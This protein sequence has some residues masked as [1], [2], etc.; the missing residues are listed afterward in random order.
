MR[1]KSCA[2][3]AKY[4]KAIAAGPSVSTCTR[5]LDFHEEVGSDIDYMPRTYGDSCNEKL[6]EDMEPIDPKSSSKENPSPLRSDNAGSQNN[7]NSDLFVKKICVRC[8]CGGDMMVCA[9]TGCPVAF[10]EKCLPS[11]PKFDGSGNYYCPYCAYRG[12]VEKA[13]MLRRK[14]MLAKRNLLKFLNSVG[15]GPKRSE[16]EAIVHE[17]QTAFAPLENQ[18]QGNTKVGDSYNK[19]L[20]GS[21]VDGI[22]AGSSPLGNQNLHDVK[23]GHGLKEIQKDGNIYDK[24]GCSPRRIQN[25]DN[26]GVAVGIRVENS[27]TEVQASHGNIS[28]N[29]SEGKH[30]IAHPEKVHSLEKVTCQSIIR[31]RSP[32]ARRTNAAAALANVRQ[33]HLRWTKEEEEML[34]EGVQRFSGC[35]NKSIPWSRIL[36]MGMNVFDPARRPSDLKDKWKKI[37]PKQR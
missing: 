1:K 18:N 7:T 5:Q 33:R 20:K 34:K 13:E 31:V 32:R 22:C 25:K 12:A 17:K 9:G 26:Y 4:S 16:K 8:G 29:A 15:D 23:V 36:E 37:A 24:Q 3:R 6:S 2:S 11:T 14:A 30:K 28:A 10:H 35:G 27:E 19:S 21:M